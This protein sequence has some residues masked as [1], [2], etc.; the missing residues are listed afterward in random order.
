VAVLHEVLC[1][2]PRFHS[3]N[4]AEMY[5]NIL[6]KPLQLKP[7]ITN[8]A[9]HLLEGLLQKDW[10]KG[11][12]AMGDFMEIKSHIFFSLI[13]WDDSINKITQPFNPNVSRSSYLQHFSPEVTD[14]SVPSSISR[15]PDS[16]LV[17]ARGKEAAEA[18]LS[19]SYIPP[20]DSF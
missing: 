8:S 7:K 15:S 3:R 1:G 17:T 14:E 5:G 6:N 20:M 9:T 18:F 12:S 11:L 19:F 2:L 4:T 10:T 13:N 16:I